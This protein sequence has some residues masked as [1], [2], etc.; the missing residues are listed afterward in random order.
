MRINGSSVANNT[1][2][3]EGGGIYNSGTVRFNATST[4]S[5]NSTPQ[6]VGV[7]CPIIPPLCIPTLVAPTEGT[8]MDNG[9][10]DGTDSI[11]WDFDWSDC[12]EATEYHLYVR[13]ADASVPE[14]DVIAFDM[15]SYQYTCAGCY[16]PDSNL[17]D[18]RWKVRVKIDGDWSAWSEVW[19]FDVE[20]VDTD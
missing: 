13:N 16:I 9:R 17:L 4:V 5:G 2:S 8:L 20:P 14:V 7:A 15:S 3:S 12:A 18:W 11:V 10:L 1:A 6:C 19:T